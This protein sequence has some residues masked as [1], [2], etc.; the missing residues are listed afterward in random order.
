M[1]VHHIY[2]RSGEEWLNRVFDCRAVETGG[3]IKRQALDVEREVGH[4][5]FVAAVRSRG[6]RLLRTRTY[7]VILCDRGPVE[8]VC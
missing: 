2:R 4:D 5:A 8:M 7:Y 1:K 3:V 6:F